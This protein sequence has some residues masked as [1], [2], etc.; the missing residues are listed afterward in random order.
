[1]LIKQHN[2]LFD[3]KILKTFKIVY[4]WGKGLALFAN[5]KIASAVRGDF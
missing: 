2:R 4:V 3:L 1:M 5:K